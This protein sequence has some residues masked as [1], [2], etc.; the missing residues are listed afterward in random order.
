MERGKADRVVGRGLGDELEQ[1]HAMPSEALVPKWPDSVTWFGVKT[2]VGHRV[3]LARGGGQAYSVINK[4]VGSL[5]LTVLHLKISARRRSVGLVGAR[6]FDS[7][8]V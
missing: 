4:L 7:G 3:Y 2:C 5:H 6:G 8:V 1:A